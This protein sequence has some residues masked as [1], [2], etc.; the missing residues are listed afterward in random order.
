MKLNAAKVDFK[1]L[2]H[3]VNLRSLDIS[4]TDWHLDCQERN[5]KFFIT[6]KQI[7]AQMNEKDHKIVFFSLQSLF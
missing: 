6:W 4:P 7:T 3:G 1:G 2:N 5:S